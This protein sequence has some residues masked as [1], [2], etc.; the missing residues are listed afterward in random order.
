MLEGC[1]TCH[2]VHA[3]NRAPDC[4]G[5]HPIE[6]GLAHRG[7]HGDA[8]CRDCHTAHAPAPTAPRS[9]RGTNPVSARC[10][11][12]HTE[13]A[14]GAATSRVAAFD[15]PAAVF[16]PDGRRWEP[17]RGLPLFDEGGQQIADGQNGAMTCQTCHRVHGPEPGDGPKL[18]RAGWKQACAACH[19]IDALP[20]YQWF[21][22]ARRRHAVRPESAP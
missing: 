12:C 10:L 22:D 7:G 3:P 4:A 21:H 8:S 11:A 14:R 20:L 13:D 1:G 17:L 18:G 2:D 19:G 16:L 5:C 15:H 9:A 6:A